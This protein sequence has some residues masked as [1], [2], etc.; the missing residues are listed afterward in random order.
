MFWALKLTGAIFGPVLGISM[1]SAIYDLFVP[2]APIR[3]EAAVMVTASVA[4]FWLGA[5]GVVYLYIVLSG[6]IMSR[7]ERTSRNNS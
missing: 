6:G 5:S 2:E 4:V 7:D 1:V 3:T